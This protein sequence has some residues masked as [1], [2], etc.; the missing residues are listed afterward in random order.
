MSGTV[1]FDDGNE[2]TYGGY[3]TENDFGDSGGEYAITDGVGNTDFL[4]ASCDT[5][6]HLLQTI[7]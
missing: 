2:L 1:V 6:L 7:F 3:A 4:G 5:V